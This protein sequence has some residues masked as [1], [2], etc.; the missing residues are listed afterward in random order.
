[1]YFLS[2][3]D[4]I[5]TIHV[6]GSKPEKNWKGREIEVPLPQNLHPAGM[7]ESFFMNFIWNLE[8]V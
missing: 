1:M 3:P 7:D 8:P 5:K 6:E 4:V 2:E